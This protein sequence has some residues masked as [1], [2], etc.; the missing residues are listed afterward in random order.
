MARIGLEANEGWLVGISREVEII[1]IYKGLLRYI[2]K[3]RVCESHKVQKVRERDREQRERN[4]ERVSYKRL[5]V[6]DRE[7]MSEQERNKGANR[8]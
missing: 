6:R 5:R 7:C 1:H 2:E 3:Q 8:R 4:R